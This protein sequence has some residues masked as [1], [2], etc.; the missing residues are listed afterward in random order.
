M[1][2]PIGK[3]AE[4]FA[5]LRGETPEW[6]DNLVEWANT[7]LCKNGRYVGISKSQWIERVI[8]GS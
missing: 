3:L 1:N 7:S 4:A 5:K 8:N 2:S 6:T